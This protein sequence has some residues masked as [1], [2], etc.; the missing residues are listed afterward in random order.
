[1]AEI[2]N[3]LKPAPFKV[4]KK[5][6]PEQLHMEF[7]KYMDNFTEFLTT[8]EADGVHSALQAIVDNR[9]CAGCRKAKVFL[10]L[11]GGAEMKDLFEHVGKVEAEDTFEAAVEKIKNGI[12]SQTNQATA[13]FKLFQQ[14]PQSGAH[15]AD[16][17]VKL[18]EQSDRCLWTGYDAKMAARDAILFQTDDQK[19]QRKVIAEDLNFDDTVKYGLALE[20]GAR[21][22]E[23]MRG[24]SN[25]KENDRVAALE[26]QVRMLTAGTR[27]FTKKNDRFDKKTKGGSEVGKCK[28]CTRP[29]HEEGRCPGKKIECY[30]CKKTGHFKGSE[31]CSK[32]PLSKQSIQLPV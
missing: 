22:V 10:K 11:I 4:R 16:W 23:E 15:F 14:M 21:K 6:D 19:L 28:T 1:M 5:G 17:Y 13:R 3:L 8:T 31:A 32:K 2:L 26:E 12:K 7:G 25:K 24:A 27:S 20:Q 18:R 30:A 9:S 29:T